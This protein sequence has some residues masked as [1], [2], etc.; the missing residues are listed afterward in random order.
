MSKGA[1]LQ[2]NE[3]PRTI[4][5]FKAKWYVDGL[6]AEFD[7]FKLKIYSRGDVRKA[8]E[9]LQLFKNRAIDVEVDLSSKEI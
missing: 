1:I 6:S 2:I 8:I 5:H 7:G 9:I 4:S 3:R